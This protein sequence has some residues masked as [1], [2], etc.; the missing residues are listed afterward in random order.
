MSDAP[1]D[2]QSQPLPPPEP[3]Q[4]DAEAAAQARDQV[5]GAAKAVFVAALIWFALHGDDPEP[6]DN[7]LIVKAA[8]RL[9]SAM[10]RHRQ[11]Q[12]AS[13][14][15]PLTGEAKQR[16][17]DDRADDIVKLALGDV[18]RHYATVEKR[19]RRDNPDVSD[20]QVRSTFR[21]DTPWSEAAGRTAATRLAAQTA[22]GMREEVEAET[23]AK[24]SLMWISRG[25][26]KV[27]HLHRELHGRVRPPGTPFHIWTQ[28]GQTLS[29]PGDPDAPLDAVINCRCAL[30]LIP[31]KDA[32][33]AEQVFHVP[34]GDFTIAASGTLDP[35]VEQAWSD[36]REELSRLD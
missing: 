35:L 18:K 33:Y 28:T 7:S 29:Y 9:A 24:H 21:L 10:F 13:K 17:L 20:R 8:R 4:A 27:R 26:P 1:A 14:V 11:K 5:E 12:S 6:G 19:V 32:A 16:W 30:L 25:D 2:P 31:S 36:L 34:P 15:P 22:M 23:G 3:P